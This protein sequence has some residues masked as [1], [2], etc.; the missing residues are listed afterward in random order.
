MGKLSRLERKMGI[1]GKLLQLHAC[2]YIDTANQQ[3]H[4]TPTC[5]YYSYDSR[6]AAYHTINAF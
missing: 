3:G 5:W 6:T 1:R 4:V 2:A